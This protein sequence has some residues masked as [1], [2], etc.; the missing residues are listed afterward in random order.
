[1]ENERQMMKG[2]EWLEGGW[3]KK[4]IIENHPTL[5]LYPL[6]IGEFI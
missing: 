1:M 6:G 5:P 4:M 2:E 3:L